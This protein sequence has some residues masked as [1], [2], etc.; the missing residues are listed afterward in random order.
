[1]I[2]EKGETV[3]LRERHV[4][5]FRFEKCFCSDLVVSQHMIH[6][7]YLRLWRLNLSILTVVLDSAINKLTILLLKCLYFMSV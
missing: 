2:Y 1:M 7:Y 3:W 4:S 5:Y 6:V